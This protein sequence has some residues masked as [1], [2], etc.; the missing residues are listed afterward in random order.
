[1]YFKLVSLFI[2]ENI[3][4]KRLMGFDVKRSK[5]KA[6]GI[7]L[8]IIY[9]LAVFVGAFGY[10]FFDLGKILHDMG[11]SELLLSFICIYMLGMAFF[12]TLFR[13]SGYLFYYKDYDILAP[14][15]IH[16]RTIL[17]AKM[18]VLMIMLYLT[19]F[20]FTLPILFSYI[21]WNG[22]TILSGIYMVIG[23]FFLPLVPV[24]LISF[25]SLGVATLTARLRHAKIISIILVF[26]LMIGLFMIMFS[27]NE[28]DQNPLTGQID[29]FKGIAK[30][31]L[32]FDWYRI[33]VH[34][35]S[36]PHFMYLVLSHG[37]LFVLYLFS[38]Q[39]LVAKTNQK[40]VRVA[41]K[42]GVSAIRYIQRSPLISI[43]QKEFK[44][45]F[46]SVLYATNAGFGPIILLVASVASLFFQSKLES[47]LSEAMGVG[48]L[49]LEIMILLLIG[50]SLAMTY[51]PA[52]SLSLE[53]K[54]LWLIK[55]LPIQPKTV[56]YGKIVFNMLLAVPIGILSILLFGISL[57]IPVINQ[58][59]MILL[60][61]SFSGLISFFD[62][63]INLW[64]PKFNFVNDVEVI[65]QS[66]SAFLAIF[67]GFAWMAINGFVYVQLDKYVSGSLVFGLMSVLNLVLLIP[68]VWLIET[69][70][71]LFFR[72]YQG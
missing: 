25:L 12:I 53:G 37:I 31:Y 29:L 38:I 39:G 26:V 16:P 52:I 55:S 6:I 49:P 51:T 15:P 24:A 19:S 11:Q 50:F 45:F 63:I 60:V 72:K 35:E 13:A 40:G 36:L 42:H 20:L 43:V 18:T 66:A 1:M 34:Q 57:K 46:N 21:Y 67:G 56:I 28:V 48:G 65:K 44:K 14:L 41:M 32:P 30:V 54:Q 71:E 10:M 33:A 62:A 17:F 4:L 69:K 7:G 59:L 22:M 70:T 61:I 64:T 27:V 2:K 58:L 47:I 23:F 8:A 3:S 9:A 68:L 5:A